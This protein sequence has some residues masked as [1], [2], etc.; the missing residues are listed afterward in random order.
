MK[1]L[2]KALVCGTILLGMLSCEEDLM[3]E[4]ENNI[5]QNSF[6]STELQINQALSG[7]YSAMVNASSRGGYEKKQIRILSY[8]Q[9]IESGFFRRNLA[10]MRTT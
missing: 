2:T 6:Y 10:V 9:N 8:P 1:S 5:T 7:V 4:P 3:L